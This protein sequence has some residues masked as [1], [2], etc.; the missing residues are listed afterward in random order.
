ML[1]V[2]YLLSHILS[3][4]LLTFLYIKKAFNW[5]LFTILEGYSM[6][7]MTGSVEACKKG[8][9]LYVGA[10]AENLHLLHI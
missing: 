1:H 7:I 10:G 3:V 2:L 4:S 8:M 5:N 9:V 6:V